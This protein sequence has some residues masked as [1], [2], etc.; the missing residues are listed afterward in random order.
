[1]EK[2]KPI[3]KAIALGSSLLLLGAFVGCRS[4]SIWP[5]AKPAPDAPAS[6]SE[7]LTGAPATTAS[8]DNDDVSIDND[9]IRKGKPVMFFGGTKSAMGSMGSL[10]FGNTRIPESEPAKPPDNTPP[11]PFPQGTPTA[12]DK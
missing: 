8:Q 2:A 3:L 7:P 10:P 9:Q 6:Q 12:P 1:M 4:N 11:N 5:F